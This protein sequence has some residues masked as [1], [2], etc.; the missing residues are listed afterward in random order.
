M[1][2][3]RARGF[4]EVSMEMRKNTKNAIF[5]ERGTKAAAGYDFSTPLSVIIPAKNKEIIWT[6]IK[7][8]MQEDEVLLIYVRSS[9]GIIKGLTLANGTGVIDADYHN[10]CENEGNIGICLLNNTDQDISLQEGERIAQGVF[11]SYLIS[12]NGNSGCNR[13]GG[14][15]SSTVSNHAS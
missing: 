4:E 15:G 13:K 14:I 1:K 2:E 5:P 3:K 10:S 7:A 12:D 9:F 8:Y 6:N 11:M